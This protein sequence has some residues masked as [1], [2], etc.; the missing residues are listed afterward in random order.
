[1]IAWE[2]PK[3]TLWVNE[4]DFTLYWHQVLVA[5]THVHDGKLN[6][7]FGNEWE[8][9]FAGNLED[10]YGNANGSLQRGLTAKLK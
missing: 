9:F 6:V 5:F 1:M 2:F 3:G 10:I 7:Q 4:D 8:E